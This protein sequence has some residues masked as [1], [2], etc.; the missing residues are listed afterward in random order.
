[1]K[2]LTRK[3]AAEALGISLQLLDDARSTRQITY[4]QRRPGCKVMFREEDL[5]AY[6]A[7]CTQPARP[8]HVVQTYRNRR[9]A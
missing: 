9:R 4:V 7:R 2:L 6:V 5:E 8:L 3:E 1:M